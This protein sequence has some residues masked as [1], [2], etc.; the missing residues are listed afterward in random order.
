MPERQYCVK[1]FE[2]DCRSSFKRNRSAH[3]Q[4][5]PQKV[6]HTEQLNHETIR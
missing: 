2:I 3:L 4:Q 6:L 5:R 1:H